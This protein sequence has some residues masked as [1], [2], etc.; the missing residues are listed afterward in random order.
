MTEKF[1]KLFLNIF[2]LNFN[3]N[4]LKKFSIIKFLDSCQSDKGGFGGGPDQISHLATTY[5]AVNALCSLNS[6]R[7][8]KCIRVKPLVEW[9][10][11]LKLE[12]GAFRM[13]ED[14]EEDLRFSIFFLF[15]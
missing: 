12:N 10:K 8:L 15:Y 11:R 6:E 1:L 9:M 14:G 3:L 2:F 4:C 5:A 7:A 13:H